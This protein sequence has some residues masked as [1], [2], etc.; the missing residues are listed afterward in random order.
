MEDNVHAK[1]LLS[2]ISYLPNGILLGH[3]DELAS[4]WD[5]DA[6]DAAHLLKQLSLIYE[7][8]NKHFL[9]TLSPNREHIT[10]H[11]SISDPDLKLVRQWHFDLANEGRGEPGNVSFLSTQAELAISQNNISFVL[12]RC[13]NG[14]LLDKD[15]I[16]TI[17]KFSNFLH[18][19]T[20][21][22]DLLQSALA[23]KHAGKLEG[24]YRGRLLFK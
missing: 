3:I 4:A 5:A 24:I 23:P 22:G 14:Y 19:S 15:L 7:S 9:T 16:E 18:W 10:R 13:I 20:P 11:R 21:N 8:S 2:I 6:D 1:R 17:I 12:Q